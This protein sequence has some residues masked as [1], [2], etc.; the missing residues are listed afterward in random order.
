LRRKPA[1]PNDVWHLDEVVVTI[2]GRRH[3]LWRAVDQHGYVL[4]EIVQTRRSP[5]EGRC[6]PDPDADRSIGKD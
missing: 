5:N 1:S 3:W 6:R 2:G 4:D